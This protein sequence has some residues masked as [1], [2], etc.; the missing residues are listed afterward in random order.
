MKYGTTE[1][2]RGVWK[3]AAKKTSEDLEGGMKEIWVGMK[4][5]TT[6]RREGQASE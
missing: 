1:K 2:K 5:I 6:N 3:D 4:E